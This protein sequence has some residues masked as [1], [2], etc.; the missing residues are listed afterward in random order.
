[1][2]SI[3]YTRKA[4]TLRDA[5]IYQNADATFNTGRVQGDFTLKLS[6][7]GTGNQSTSGITISEVDATNNPGEYCI[8]VASSAFVA[9]NGTYVL[10]ITRTAD[11]KY[12]FEQVYIVND[13]GMPTSTP[14]SFTATTSD[15]RITD[16]VNP[17]VGAS[18]YLTIGGSFYTQTTTTTGGVWGPV[19]LSDGT[20]TIYAQASG[21]QQA[22]GTITVSGATV[23]GP[24][25]D[26]ALTAGS[27]TNPM[28]ASQ[29]WAYA[30]RMAVD[31]TGTKAD[32][33]IKSAVNDALDMVSSERLWPHL[34]R[35]GYL[36]LNGAYSTG[37]ITLTSGSATVTLATGTWPSWAASG[38]LFFAGQII[39]IATRTS[40]TEVVIASAWAKATL[41]GQSYVLFQNEYDLPDDLWR[42]HKPLPGQRWG[43]GGEESGP[44][45]L[46]AAENAAVYGQQFASLFCVHNGSWVCWPYPNESNKLA[47]TYYARPARLVS[48]ADIS[49]W[50]PVHIEPLKRAIDYQLARQLG[51]V[52]AGDSESTMK[53][54]REA[55]NR[56]SVQD[57]QPTDIPAVGSGWQS[58]H[59]RSMD[60]KRL[61]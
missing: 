58:Y 3:V 60:W 51:R 42:F 53:A 35:R 14:A 37:T 6:K 23:T 5:F 27:T 47:Y 24:G 17:I 4:L 8:T 54:Y 34:L 10:T 18:V 52:V 32:T 29:L 13:T 16:G 31:L 57:K 30:R 12:T 11:P 49:D 46:F 20:Y 26:I 56:I 45:E 15:G 22:T 2:S 44:T 55:I 61:P 28:S 33:I 41:T 38:R 59:D 7:D 43:W 48:D 19:Y 40:D 25:A 39:D 1:M 21:Y 50:D 36:D 9:A